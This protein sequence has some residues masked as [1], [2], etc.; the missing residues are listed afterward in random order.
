MQLCQCRLAHFAA[1][2]AFGHIGTC[3]RSLLYL[4]MYAAF[5]QPRAALWC[6]PALLYIL[7]LRPHPHC[8]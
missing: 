3:V 2:D 6:I 7:R 4:V 5:A 1:L 8:S